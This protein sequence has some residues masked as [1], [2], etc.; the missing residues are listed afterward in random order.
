VNSVL[1]WQDDGAVRDVLLA[2]RK[3]YA[4]CVVAPVDEARVYPAKA[5]RV[6]FIRP[7]YALTPGFAEAVH[8]LRRDLLAIHPL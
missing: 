2:N 5:V 6:R 4:A 1:W 8:T 7:E 3:D